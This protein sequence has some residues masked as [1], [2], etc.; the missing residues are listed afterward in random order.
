MNKST[1]ILTLS[2]IHIYE[3]LAQ[4]FRRALL[5]LIHLN[6]PPFRVGL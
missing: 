5:F 4:L 6:I 3:L 1:A 2:L